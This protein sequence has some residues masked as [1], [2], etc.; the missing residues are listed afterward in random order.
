MSD[1]KAGV[2]TRG[3]ISEFKEF[4]LRG[5]VIDMAVGVIIG[6]AFGKISASLVNDVFMPL[7][8]LL[9][10]GLN[11]ASMNIVL[12]PASGEAEAVMLNLGTFISTI[13]DF[14]LIALCVF[15]MIKLIN[16]L[17]KKQKDAPAEPVAP[18][19]DIALLTEI[20]DLLKD[21]E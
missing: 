15:I 9:L 11:F 21:K 18:A 19:A 17:R 6:G 3:W 20:R 14:A 13:V 8:G 1:K 7:I 12:K 10:G 16:S 4:A 2:K 5:N